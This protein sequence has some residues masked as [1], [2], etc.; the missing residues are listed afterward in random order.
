MAGALGLLAGPL[1]A[2]RGHDLQAHA[3]AL[4]GGETFVGGGGGAGVRLGLGTRLAGLVTGG[5]AESGLAALRVEALGTYHLRPPGRPR[6]TLY[7]GAGLGLLATG[8][9]TQGHVVVVVGLEAA[10]RSRGGWFIEAGVGGG[11]RLS[12]GYRL[13]RVRP[14]RP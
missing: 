9:G 3:L 11:A 8:N 12:L 13:T 14:R 5:R 6:A 2:Q 7:G 10:P 4:V 1:L